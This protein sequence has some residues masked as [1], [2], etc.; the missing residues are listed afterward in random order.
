MGLEGQKKE[1]EGRGAPNVDQIVRIKGDKW[2]DSRKK[3]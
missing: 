1:W 2:A 3:E